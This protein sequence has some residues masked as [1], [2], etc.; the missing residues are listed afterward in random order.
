MKFVN[1]KP[2]DGIVDGLTGAPF[3]GNEEM[4]SVLRCNKCFA[5]YHQSSVDT[6]ED[7]GVTCIACNK[8]DA[9]LVYVD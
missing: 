2:V 9:M 3:T 6:M 4:F 7:E 8:A 1:S 5:H